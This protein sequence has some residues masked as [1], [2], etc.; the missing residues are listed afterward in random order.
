MNNIENSDKILHSFSYTILSLSWFF[1]FKPIK[2]IKE[3]L[4]IAFVVFCYGIIIEVLQSMLTTYRTG[5][6]YDIIANNIG[7]LIALIT[8]E[9]FYKYFLKIIK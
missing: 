1:Y 7:I 4:V 2:K 3:K 6:L 8:F 9:T 5:S